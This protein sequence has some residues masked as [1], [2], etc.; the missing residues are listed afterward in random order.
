MALIRIL[1]STIIYKTQLT[2]YI[3]DYIISQRNV[4]IIS[5]SLNYRFLVKSAINTIVWQEDASVE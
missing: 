2:L 5:D 3:L 4:V 1:N